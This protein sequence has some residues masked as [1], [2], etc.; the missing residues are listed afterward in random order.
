MVFCGK[1]FYKGYQI[2][3]DEPLMPFLIRLFPVLQI[4]SLNVPACPKGVLTHFQLCYVC[5]CINM[6]APRQLQNRK[7][8]LDFLARGRAERS[9]THIL[10]GFNKFERFPGPFVI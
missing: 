10:Q 9:V 2:E 6:T 5:V 4:L 7:N 3:F 8:K 1:L